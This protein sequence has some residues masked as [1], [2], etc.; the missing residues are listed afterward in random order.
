MGAGEME[1]PMASAFWMAA[2]TLLWGLVEARVD[3]LHP[4]VAEGA[5]D[6]LGPCRA[7]RGQPSLQPPLSC[8]P[9]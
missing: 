6:Y 2:S 3:N 7:R 8:A 4:G 9:Q 5:G 1:I